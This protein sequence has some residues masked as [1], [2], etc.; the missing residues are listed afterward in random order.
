MP[1][2]NTS[3]YNTANPE[4]D[5]LQPDPQIKEERRSGKDRRGTVR[6]GSEKKDRR[7]NPWRQEEKHAH[8]SLRNPRQF[9]KKG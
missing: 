7:K 2:P 3:L 4:T 9:W 8:G 6:F 1:P 5:K